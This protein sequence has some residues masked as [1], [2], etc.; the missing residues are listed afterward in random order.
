MIVALC[1]VSCRQRGFDEFVNSVAAIVW[2]CGA[3]ERVCAGSNV[4]IRRRQRRFR[5]L[6]FGVF[7][8]VLL[9]LE[10]NSG[11]WPSSTVSGR[12]HN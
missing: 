2:R 10:F 1:C 6:E 7:S 5:Y 3:I 11:K 4:P 12:P 8:S 9:C